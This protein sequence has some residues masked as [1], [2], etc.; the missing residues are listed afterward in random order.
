MTY[1]DYGREQ[2]LDE[3]YRD[4]QQARGSRR[5][6]IERLMTEIVRQSKGTYELR[7]E[8][9]DATRSG[10]RRRVNYCREELRRMKAQE[11]SGS[12]IQV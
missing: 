2:D 4:Y 3:L 12:R 10:D 1:L 8:L 7:R 6:E 11:V 5:L 9:I